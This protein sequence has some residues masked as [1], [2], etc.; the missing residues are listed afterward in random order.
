MIDEG[1]CYQVLPTPSPRPSG[2]GGDEGLNLTWLWIAISSLAVL[3]IM[4]VLCFTVRKRVKRAAYLK[5]EEERLMRLRDDEQDLGENSER[6][7]SY[8]P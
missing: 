8:E 2:K 1:N 4:L 5:K 3:A 6:S 7:N